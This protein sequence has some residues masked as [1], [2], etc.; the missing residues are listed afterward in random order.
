MSRAE[1]AEHHECGWRGAVS[2]AA[3]VRGLNAGEGEGLFKRKHYIGASTVGS[4][5]A[6]IKCLQEI[7]GLTE[8]L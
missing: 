3:N 7:R 8:G 4:K 5:L 6:V 1:P 2:L